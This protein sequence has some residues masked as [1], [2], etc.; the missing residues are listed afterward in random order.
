[1]P[2]YIFKAPLLYYISPVSLMQSTG[3]LIGDVTETVQNS[4]KI[5]LSAAA[6]RGSLEVSLAI[7]MILIVLSFVITGRKEAKG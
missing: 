2:P 4:E 1:M 7:A 3:F 5:V 6:G